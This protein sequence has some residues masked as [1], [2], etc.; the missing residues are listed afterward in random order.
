ML[1]IE[2]IRQAEAAHEPLFFPQTQSKDGG[3][4]TGAN[5]KIASCLL[6]LIGAWDESGVRL[7]LL[8]NSRDLS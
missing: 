8:R 3:I 2:S 4:H 7:R 1:N 5:D 6:Y